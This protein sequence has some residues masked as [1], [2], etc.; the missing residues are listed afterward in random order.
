[1]ARSAICCEKTENTK[2][3]PSGKKDGA[4]CRVSARD[5]FSEVNC[6]GVPPEA[7]IRFSTLLLENTM[8]LSLFQAPLRLNPGA[9][10]IFSALPAVMLTV[11]REELSKKPTC[12]LSGDQNGA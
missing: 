6:A 5:K 9:S 3:L 2:C 10:Q 11:L 7:E 4:V 12:W 1:M 8:T